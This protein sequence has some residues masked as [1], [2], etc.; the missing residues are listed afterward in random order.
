MASKSSVTISIPSKALEPTEK[1]VDNTASSIDIGIKQARANEGAEIN[2][3][4]AG[5]PLNEIS[6]P[7][8]RDD[9][10]FEEYYSRLASWWLS[11]PANRSKVANRE[12][13]HIQFSIKKLADRYRN[14]LSSREAGRLVVG[15]LNKFYNASGD[16]LLKLCAQQIMFT[17]L[18]EDIITHLHRNNGILPSEAPS[19]S[20]EEHNS[21]IEVVRR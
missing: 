13:E 7:E 1:P 19:S 12:W 10:S 4:N 11:D 17:M 3:I 18:Y 5:V 8:K 14:N 20:S 2:P 15:F 16:E 21:K 6:R 9:E